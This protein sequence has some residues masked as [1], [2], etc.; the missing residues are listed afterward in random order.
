M[1]AAVGIEHFEN[2]RLAGLRRGAWPNDSNVIM[3]LRG[4]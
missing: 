4:A 3:N 1:V 2:G